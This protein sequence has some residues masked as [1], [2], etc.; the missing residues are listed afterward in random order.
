MVRIPE[1][2]APDIKNKSFRVSAEVEI[3]AGGAEGLLVTQGGRFAGWGLYLLGGRPVFFY[4]LAGVEQFRVAAQEKLPPG[5]HVVVFDFKY[6]G[7]G[8]GKGGLGTLTVDGKKAAE[9]R[10]PRTLPFRMSL[11]E[12][13][14]VGEDTGTAVSADYEVPFRFTGTLNKVVI[15]IEA[16][17]LT[18]AEERALD[19]GEGM[20]RMAE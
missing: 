1:G 7:G 13:L 5:K 19:Q 2:S 4:N 9:A 3:P 15:H 8:L 14:D 11:D 6:D 16:P 18:N 10:F 12:T 17:K 20:S